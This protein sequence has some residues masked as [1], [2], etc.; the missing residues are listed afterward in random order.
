MRLPALTLL[1]LLLTFREVSSASST[2]TPPSRLNRAG[3]RAYYKGQADARRDIRHHHIAIASSVGPGYPSPAFEKLLLH[4]YKIY[5]LI[6]STDE[7]TDED[8]GYR[9]GYNDVSMPEIERRYG[10]G[11]LDRAHAESEKKG[12]AR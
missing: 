12:G 11:V 6:V 3:V 1:L 10:K 7:M 9:T 8:Y 2:P 4:R 5:I